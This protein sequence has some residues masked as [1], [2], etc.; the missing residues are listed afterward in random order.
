MK[1][2]FPRRGHHAVSLVAN[3][4]LHTDLACRDLL[5]IRI[6]LDGCIESFSDVGV[7]YGVR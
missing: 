4:A 6:L 1:E 7:P 3:I 5:R 2:Y